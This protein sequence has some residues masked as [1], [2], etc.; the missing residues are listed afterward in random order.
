MCNLKSISPTYPILVY[1]GDV[2]EL[3]SDRPVFA[4]RSLVAVLELG[5]AWISVH[6]NCNRRCG[7]TGRWPAVVCRHFQLWKEW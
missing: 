4:D 2:E 6:E 3:L 5:R 1:G 7:N